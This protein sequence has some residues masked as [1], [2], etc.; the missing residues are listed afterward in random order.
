MD[1]VKLGPP[2]TPRREPELDRDQRAVLERLADVG[3]GHVVV[4]GA[5]G[6]GKTTAAVAAAA[7]AVTSGRI[8]PAKVLLLAP[9]RRAAAALRDRVSSAMGVPT[10][11][12]PVRTAASWAYAI[13][14]AVADA[15]SSPRPQLVSGAEQ[16]VVLR[17][18]LAGH[19]RGTGAAID[20][21]GIL[22]AEATSLPGFRRELRDLLMRAAEAGLG[23]DALKD[24]GRRTARPEWER[25]A[26]AFREYEQVMA[27]RSLPSDQGPRY[28]PAEVV[29]AAADEL[30]A[31][32]DSAV[33]PGPEWSL[34]LVDDAQDMTRA[35]IDLVSVA[36]ARGARV[37]LLGN[38]D[39]SVQGYRGAAPSFLAQAVLPAPA[40]W[41]ATVLRLEGSH[42]QVASLA[43]VA[44]SIASR[45]PTA[46]VGSA[47]A[48][49]V[50]KGE[51]PVDVI[52][53]PRR[54]AGIRAVA[55]GLRSLHLGLD[56]DPVPW[57]QMVVIARSSAR[58]REARSDLVAADIPCEALGDG[59]ALHREP[60]V[61]PL[62]AIMR[63]ALGSAWTI[64]AATEVLGSRAVGLDAIALRRLRRALVREERA[65]GGNRPGNDLLVDAL[66]DPARLATVGGREARRAALVAQ[67]AA[68]AAAAA[69]ERGTPGAMLWAV[70][71]RLAVADA[72]RDGAIAGSARDDADLDAVIALL[73][74]AEQFSQR[75][76]EAAPDA[77]LAYLEAQDFA[78]DTLAPTASVREGVAFATPASAAGREWDVVVVEGLEE[79]LWPNLRLRDSVLGAQALAEILAGRAEPVPAPADDERRAEAASSA[80]DA[81]LADETRSLY[82]AITRARRRVIVSAPDGVSAE[83]DVRP[84]RYVGWLEAA[85]A[86]G[87]DAGDVGGLVSLRDVVATLRREAVALPAERRAGHATML[88]RLATAGVA[89]AS[90]R[91]WLDARERSSEAP[92]WGEDARVT[93][94]PSKV[95]AAEDC[96]LKWALEAAGG[97]RESGDAQRIGNLVHAIA[98]EMPRGT[99]AEF[100]R[101]LDARWSEIGSLDTWVGRVKRQRAS[102]MVRKLAE[103]AE[104]VTSAEVRTEAGFR[105]EV[106]RALLS[107]TADRVHVDDGRA[108][109]A[110]LKTGRAALSADEGQANAQLAMYQLAAAHGAFADVAEADGAELVFV[111]T[112]AARA[113]VRSQDPLDVPAGEARL[114]DAVETMAAASFEAR[115]GPTC[116]HCAV[117]RSC[118]AQPEGG[119]VGG[120]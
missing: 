44:A 87:R 119:S 35:A 61:A 37:V 40:G 29:A 54:S 105:V 93:V 69:S 43:A 111:G 8:A 90:P 94:S 53:S 34:I 50:R 110:D 41:G 72:W 112:P 22:P 102:E 3:A 49:A 89:G 20:W 81:V 46:G 5:A 15:D 62:L 11:A 95:E 13:L 4:V 18:L 83:T 39:E 77:F 68:D 108:R 12:P 1:R 73:R 78:A 106:G 47:R 45:I 88:A 114:A 57:N 113:A 17:D 10:A 48:A 55:A 38:A 27:L 21:D 6:S 25:A 86:R 71:S 79:G 63:V 42:R 33:S 16:D 7:D 26:A 76:P 115:V 103:Y 19:A 101:A 100:E 9:T 82:V 75:L 65:G 52:R 31:W 28:D 104:G 118:P 60:A 67:A 59:V 58:L 85:G 70:W 14:R 32:P 117:R 107:G 98:A 51:P 91:T 84:S 74:A 116:D 96:P 64:D 92:L 109:I 24:L 99:V 30:R 120:R 80:R 36:A 2:V 66:A 56:G 23:P 97:T